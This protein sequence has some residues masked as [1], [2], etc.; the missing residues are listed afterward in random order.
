MAAPPPVQPKEPRPDRVKL[1]SFLH[2]KAAVWFSL[3]EA[4]MEMNYVQLSKA[5]FNVVLGGL[6]N[7]V[8]AKL[9]AVAETPDAYPDPYSALKS[10]VLELYRPSKWENINQLLTF[11]ELGGMKPT[12][13]MA[14]ML[15]LLPAEVEPCL[16]FKGIFLAR[17]PADMQDHLQLRVDELDC[18]ELAQQ[19]DALW[20]ARNRQKA[21]VL[22]ALP[23]PPEP[24]S[25]VADLADAVAAVQIKK[26]SQQKRQKQGKMA[27]PPQRR[28]DR[29]DG[30]KDICSRHQRFGGRAW[31]CDSPNTCLLAG[32]VSG[33]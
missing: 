4:S 22:A 11:K 7:E 23:L 15:A 1:G 28:P 19:A 32:Q 16:I 8:V 10:R 21:K 29:R 31:E 27:K 25:I 14:E 13:M 20:V 17:M 33:N 3:A 18:H 5:K 30:P 24:D 2:S 6:P 9:G 12:D 26:G